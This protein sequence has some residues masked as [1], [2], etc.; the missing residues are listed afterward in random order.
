[1]I[2]LIPSDVALQRKA[3]K[4][5]GCTGTI[6]WARKYLKIVKDLPGEGARGG[7][8]LYMTANAES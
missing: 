3:V 4:P 2:L 7:Q 1:L 5:P 8:T 6:E